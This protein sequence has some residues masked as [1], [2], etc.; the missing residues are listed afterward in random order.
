MGSLSVIS[1]TV[2]F[3]VLVGALVASANER[4]DTRR[5]KVDVRKLD[6]NNLRTAFYLLKEY[7]LKRRP[8]GQRNAK[9]FTC[10]IIVSEEELNRE[11]PTWFE[12]NKFPEQF[13][14]GNWRVKVQYNTGG[15]AKHGENI[16][17][18]DHMDTL[19]N[20]MQ[21]DSRA[22][23]HNEYPIVL[24]YSYNIPCTLTDHT[25][26]ANLARDHSNR[27][28]S[29]T[30]YCM[31]IGYQA[32]FGYNKEDQRG[33]LENALKALVDGGV[34]VDRLV[35]RKKE[36]TIGFFVQTKVSYDEVLSTRYSF[37]TLMFECLLGQP[38]TYCCTAHMDDTEKVDA[39]VAFFVNNMVYSC[40]HNSNVFGEL[41]ERNRV[42]IK[43]CFKTFIQK[44]ISGECLQCSGPDGH[45]KMASQ[46]FVSNCV[47]QSLA[48]AK[49]FGTPSCRNDLDAPGWELFLSSWKDLYPTTPACFLQSQPRLS[50]TKRSLGPESLCSSSA[51]EPRHE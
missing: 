36:G 11:A 39:L 4:R 3:F 7:G 14:K 40:T 19:I 6:F 34:F 44:K 21:N 18:K 29:M 49:G 22:N 27:K 51:K 8:A 2:W 47:D 25:C 42:D 33:N 15:N 28:N 12:S 41:T 23:G 37:Q 16:I 46:L 1:E 50:C 43:T 30:E 5:H 17:L 48:L 13:T 10:T 38:T 35:H 24:M 9:Q 20:H 26:A 31:V 32:S 45:G